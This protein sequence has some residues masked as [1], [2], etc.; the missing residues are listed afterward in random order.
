MRKVIEEAVKNRDLRLAS[1]PKEERVP[2][3][4][5]TIT[6]ADVEEFKLA[7]HD[8]DLRK[9]IGFTLPGKE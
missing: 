5:L 7:D 6:L 2:E 1:I 3:M 8:S 4:L 9:R